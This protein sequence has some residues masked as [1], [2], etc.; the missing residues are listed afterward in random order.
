MSDRLIGGI[1]SLLT[2]YLG[3]EGVQSRIEEREWLKQAKRQQEQ[4]KI[5]RLAQAEFNTDETRK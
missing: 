4:D 2:G 5:R 1:T 3:S